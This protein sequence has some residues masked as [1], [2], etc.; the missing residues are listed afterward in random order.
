[1][2]KKDLGDFG[3]LL[4][5]LFSDVSPIVSI[6]IAL[7]LVGGIVFDYFLVT[8]VASDS[9]RNVTPGLRASFFFLFLIV[10]ACGFAGFVVGVG[11]DSLVNVLLPKSD[12]G[13]KA[14]KKPRQP[15]Y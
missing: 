1:M 13:G 14:Q 7:G 5:D 8:W 9:P 11:V 12:E 3:S 10:L 15:R 2:S 4:E 6:G